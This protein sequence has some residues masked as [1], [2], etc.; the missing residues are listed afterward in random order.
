MAG[1]LKE[2]SRLISQ[3]GWLEQS[4]RVPPSAWTHWPLP[5][6]LPTSPGLVSGCKS[7]DCHFPS[8][9][10]PGFPLE[11]N[12]DQQS[13]CHRL[14]GERRSQRAVRRGHKGQGVG[15]GRPWKSEEDRLGPC[16]PWQWQFPACQGM[17]ATTTSAVNNNNDKAR[18][19]VGWSKQDPGQSQPLQRRSGKRCAKAGAGPPRPRQ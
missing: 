3:A 4:P 19:L 8:G 13:Q 14:G 18:S 9:G 5:L 12:Y 15:A 16:G 2:G 10:L 11:P 6:S 7:W 1:W 17:V